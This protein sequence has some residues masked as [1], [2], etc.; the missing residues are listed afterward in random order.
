MS[1][2]KGSD[3]DIGGGGCFA[4]CRP[5]MYGNPS[6]TPA[7]DAGICHISLVLE[8]DFLPFVI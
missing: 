4:A 5:S 6:H 1:F 7:G 3:L 8:S 2:I